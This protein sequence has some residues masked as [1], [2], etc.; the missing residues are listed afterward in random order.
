MTLSRLILAYIGLLVLL[1]L[2]VASSFVD[3]S[4]F[5]TLTNLAIAAAK[6]AIIALAFMGFARMDILVRLSVVAGA[7]WL[8]IL[9][10]LTLIDQPMA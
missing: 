10:V 6:T 1:A 8:L 3:L 4:G 5:N 7:L 9:F 2:T